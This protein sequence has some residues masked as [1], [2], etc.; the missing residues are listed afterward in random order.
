MPSEVLTVAR[1]FKADL[2]RRE[3]V[4]MRQMANR[5]MGIIR[6][7]ESSIDE[8][9]VK[10][11]AQRAAGNAV[12]L[13]SIYR[14]ERYRQLLAQAHAE[15]MRY[16]DFAVDLVSSERATYARLGIS[17][18]LDLLETMQPG[19]SAQFN[20]LPVGSIQNM[21][22]FLDDSAPLHALLNDAWPDVIRQ[23]S[24]ALVEGVALGYNPKKIARM[25][26]DAIGGGL[27]RSLVIART[28]TMRA[29]TTTSLESYRATGVVRGYQRLAA[30][31]V[32]TC[33]LC[34]ALDGKFYKLD[35]DFASHPNCVIEGTTVSTPQVIGTSERLY[36]GLVTVITTISGN[37]LT[38]TPN[39]PV[40][41]DKGWVAANLLHEGDYVIS[42]RNS[43]GAALLVAPDDQHGPIAIEDIV[44]A[45]GEAVNVSAVSVPVAAEDFHAD[46]FGSD[47]AVIGANRFLQSSLDAALIEPTS[48][49]A[50]AIRSMGRADFL[51]SRATAQVIEGTGH[52]LYGIM[53]G[54]DILHS[55]LRSSLQLEQPISRSRPANSNASL[56]QSQADYGSHCSVCGSESVFGLASQVASDDLLIRQ[57]KATTCIEATPFEMTIKG[58]PANVMAFSDVIGIDASNVILDRI[59]NLSSRRFSGHV[60]NLETETGWYVA[61]GIITHNCRCTLISVLKDA[62]LHQWKYG[63]EWLEGLPADKQMTILGP[64]RY[65]AWKSGQFSLD[66]MVQIVPNRTWGDTLRSVPLRELV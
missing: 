37:H 43:D 35:E 26:K 14:D 4:T 29:Y 41:T 65:D 57:H 58:G 20:R 28:E 3:A 8:V 10:M 31:S 12:T 60:Y 44:A 11:A 2:A 52:A 6:R 33:P 7:L 47:V 25:M 19:I 53:G 16:E 38:V 42:S 15:F 17:N 18:A 45:F 56:F 22:A 62:P 23:T 64:G 5:Y 54:L 63:P 27:Q 24:S 40:L 13:A 61:N 49:L 9:A 66:D 30:H 50:F 59:V 51:A 36:D 46:G 48:E 1:A 32:R 55:L 39:H 21:V 34:L